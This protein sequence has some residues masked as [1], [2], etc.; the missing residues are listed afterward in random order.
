MKKILSLFV[1]MLMLMS[2]PALAQNAT[3]EPVPEVDLPDP[4]TTPDSALYFS[5]LALENLA[6]ALTFDT[7]ARL[8]KELEIAEERLAEAR[9]MAL[10][11]NFEAMAKAES[12][13]GKIMI[14]LKAEVKDISDG[15]EE[16]ELRKELEFEQRIK[17][18]SDKVEEVEEELRIKVKIRG[19]LTPEQWDLIASLI[20]SFEGQTG[21]LKI[22][23]R[24]EKGKTKI[25]I[26]QKTGRSGDELELEI[27]QE[28]GFDE[29]DREDAEEEIA[30]VQ[31]DLDDLLE[32]AEEEGFE[33]P[34]DALLAITNLLDQAKEAFA[35]EDF[36]L[37]EELAEEADDLLDDLEDSFE[38]DEKVTLCH[39]PEGQPENPQT[40][41]V[42][43]DAVAA[44]LEHGD[45]RGKCSEDVELP[46][47]SVEEE[48][49]DAEEEISKAEEK[50]AE[51]AEDGKETA[52]AEDALNRAREKLAEA[53]A[54]REAGDLE[55]AEELAEE[56]KDLANDARGKF[57]GKTAEELEDDD[58]EDEDDDD[59]SGGDDDDDDDRSGRDDD[60]DDDRSGRDED[61][62]DDRSGRDDDDRSG[63]DSSGSGSGSSGSGSSGSG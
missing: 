52:A 27:E 62:D 31:E 5:D 14:K 1:V 29:E 37:A 42:G 36:E 46:A 38:D 19:E 61:D 21:E 34:E 8:E 26:E 60:D 49:E 51:A 47:L 3:T 39:I 7:D 28:L 18:H 11:G 22:E 4:G 13:H 33:L 15:D 63:S 20:A 25:K 23:I 9:A 50:L 53:R 54:A 2:V 30:D 56:A 59:R 45:S 12:E 43:E 32:E 58:D 10:E 35:A 57:I 6:L 41:R 24:N 16:G 17:R 44:H 48:I 55:T 40:I